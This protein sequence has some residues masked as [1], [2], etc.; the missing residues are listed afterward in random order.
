MIGNGKA[1]H[2]VDGRY[3]IDPAEKGGGRL[4]GIA[5]PQNGRMRL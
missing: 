1:D 2:V 3:A 5:W 4:G